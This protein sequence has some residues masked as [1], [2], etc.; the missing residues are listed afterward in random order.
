MKRINSVLLALGLVLAFSLVMATPVGAAATLEV[1]PGKTYATIQGAVNAAS[2]GDTVLVYASTYSENVVIN[3]QVTLQ[4]AG[5]GAIVDAGATLAS[6]PTTIGIKIAA[7]GV[8]VDGMEVVNAR[9]HWSAGIAASGNIR[10]ITVS[11]CTVHNANSGINLYETGDGATN[12]ITE[13]TV[14]DIYNDYSTAG[15]GII[16]WGDSTPCNDTTISD[17]DV[18]ST[19]RW[20]IALG[21]DAVAPCVDNVISGNNIHDN[22]NTEAIGVGLI[23]AVNNS[24]TDNDI[25]GCQIGIG[26][27]KG[28]SN[29]DI[30]GNTIVNNEMGMGFY[31][32]SGLSSDANIVEDNTISSNTWQGVYIDNCDDN[33]LLG[34]TVADNWVGIHCDH[35]SDGNIVHGNIISS[36]NPIN[37]YLTGASTD[38]AITCNNVTS[39]GW[40]AIQVL[41]GSTCVV[42]KNNIEGNGIGLWNV[43]AGA[44]LI[45]AE[46]NWWGDDSGPNHWITNPAATGDAV[47]DNVDY[48]PW[49]DNSVSTATATGTASFAT[50]EGNVL[51]LTAMAP[52]AT[53]P[54]ALPHGMFNFTICC[55]TGS[56]V[57]LTITFPDPIPVGYRWW[58]YVGGSWYSLPIG[59]DDGDETITVTLRDNVLPDD[60]DTVPGQ[61]TDQGGP[62]EPGAV[63]WATYPI[64]KARVLLPWIALGLAAAAGASLLVAR[65]RRT[66]T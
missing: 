29:N 44:T 4:A 48:T 38:T 46:N 60:E 39:A 37:V 21:S 45:D 55:L 17:N 8:T 28:T 50:S 9:G 64:N 30:S 12:L 65:R 19:Q 11:D 10:G 7:S 6:D 53:P 33:E 31:E 43:D 47:T 24:I 14:Y 15:C 57:T 54:V 2:V 59:S 56:T 41:G 25:S 1:G 3:K 36:N 52:P 62:G 34:N 63:G 16:A 23:N 5:A 49:V 32:N 13:N 27:N 26:L 35:G 20:S 40:A 22:N 51:G 58:K 61:I 18:Y 66:T 42:N